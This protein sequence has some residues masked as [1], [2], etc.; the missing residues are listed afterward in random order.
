MERNATI[1]AIFADSAD[2]EAMSNYLAELPEVISVTADRSLATT[3]EQLAFNRIEPALTIIPGTLYPES[4]PLLVRYVRCCFPN[5]E[6]LVIAQASAPPPSLERFMADQV[7]HLIVEPQQI[8]VAAGG[9]FPLSLAIGNLI[10]KRQ[11]TID[12]YVKEGTEIREFKLTFS[13]E[14]EKIIRTLEDA[15]VGDS[16]EHEMLRHKGALLADEML[17]NAFYGAPRSDDGMKMFRKGERRQILPQENIAF[18]FAFDGE[19]LAMEMQDGWGSLGADL[20]LEYLAKNSAN[21]EAADDAGG[22]GLFII[23]RFLDQ[24]H[25]RVA[26]GKETLIGG[27]L[28]KSSQIPPETLHGFHITTG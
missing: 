5:T 28:R 4:M 18:R 21:M 15:I 2:A 9:D 8:S 26:P 17:E 27:H 24:F 20:V 13:E 1:L 23:W 6:I 16:P 10:E 12:Q 25:V 7:R 3:L 19:T 14:K 11:W 22:R